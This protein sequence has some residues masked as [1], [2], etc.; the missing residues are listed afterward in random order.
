MRGVPRLRCAIVA[1]A[2]RLDPHVEDARAAL[3]DV[4]QFGGLVVIEVV[5]QAE[6]V[7]QRRGEHPRA[8]RRADE[9]EAFERQLQ[10]FRIRAAVDDEVD[11]E[12]FHRRIEILFDHRAEPVNLVDEQH[13]AGFEGGEDADQV[14]RFFE[15]RPG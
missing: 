12:I 2:G 14:L 11:L 15:R 7:A 4:L 3:D 5:H 1:R 9:R 10:R 13:V 6:A 8:R